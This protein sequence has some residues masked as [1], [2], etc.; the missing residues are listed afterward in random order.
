VSTELEDAFFGG[1][2]ESAEDTVV[3]EQELPEPPGEDASEADWDSYLAAF[4][5]DEPEPDQDPDEQV[6]PFEYPEYPPEAPVGALEEGVVG[7]LRRQGLGEALHADLAGY[8]RQ[9]AAAPEFGISDEQAVQRVTGEILQAREQLFRSWLGEGATAAQA[10]AALAD[11]DIE[12][13]IEVGLQGERYRA[14][15]RNTSLGQWR[16]GRESA[17]R[18]AALAGEPPPEDIMDSPSMRRMRAS[19]EARAERMAEQQAL[20]R[21]HG[22]PGTSGW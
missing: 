1:Q 22:L 10:I 3:V 2:V 19:M 20:R 18:K 21:A 13:A 6:D 16:E 14:A 5:T 11:L 9:A 4:E 7:E 17:A 12:A 8:V 15:T